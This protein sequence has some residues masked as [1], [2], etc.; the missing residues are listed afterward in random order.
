MEDPI[1]FY[2]ISIVASYSH[3]FEFHSEVPCDL[4]E[5]E[6][7]ADLVWSFI[8]GAFTLTGIESRHL[9]VQISGVQERKNHGKN[10]GKNPFIDTME[11]GQFCDGV[12]FCG[13]DQI[14]LAESS[15]LHNPKADKQFQDEHRLIRALRDSWISQMKSTC[16]EAVPPRDFAV[17]GACTF[18]EQT[19]FVVMD[20]R[21][22]FRLCQF[23]M[24]VIPLEKK[25]QMHMAVLACLRLAYRIQQ[26]ISRRRLA[27]LAT[28]EKQLE[29]SEAIRKTS[30]TSST[31][32]KPKKI[33]KE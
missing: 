17:F 31:P 2:L 1:A 4:N 23:D 11:Q 22:V 32:T 8:R 16:R 15:Q 10:H 5:R 14:F 25:R 6:G 27:T 12:G 30:I 24:F 20:F 18:K 29:M 9:E 26:E 19:K 33:R 28:F 21:G 13:S 7:Y 3:Y